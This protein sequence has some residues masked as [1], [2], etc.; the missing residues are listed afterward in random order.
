MFLGAQNLD[1]CEVRLE[2]VAEFVAWL[3]RP[4]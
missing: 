4:P 3:R 2:N 1:W